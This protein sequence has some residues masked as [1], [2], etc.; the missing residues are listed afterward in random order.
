MLRLADRVV[1]S[2]PALAES[3]AARRSDTVVV[4]N[5]LD[6]RLWGDTPPAPRQGPNRS[7]VRILCMGTAT[8]DADFAMI[9]PALT[10]LHTA[11]GARIAVDMIGFSGA[12]KLPYWVN[13]LGMPPHASKSYPG[14]V[15]WMKAQPGW[16]IGLVP[17]VASGF[18]RCKSPIKTLDYAALGL[19]ILASDVPVYRGSV[20]DGPGGFLVPN[21]E[22]AWY[23]ALSRLVRDTDLRRRLGQGASEAFS[24][25]GTLAARDEAWRAALS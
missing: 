25:G 23:N 18:N 6:E 15:N 13:R 8:H 22:D 20:A 21:D 3:L 7:P 10:R 12:N 1:V 4:P 16:D 19:A 5:G 11:F 14:F 17:L 9:L 24:A 2:T